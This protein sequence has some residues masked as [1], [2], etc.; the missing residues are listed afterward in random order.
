MY[1]PWPQRHPS[2]RSLGTDIA[3]HLKGTLAAAQAFD[4][5]DSFDPKAT[6]P[7][8]LFPAAPGVPAAT[9]A[10]RNLLEAT[11]TDS[12]KRAVVAA[13]VSTS[14]AFDALLRIVKARPFTR[15]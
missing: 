2:C 3:Q 8:P 6:A 11:S 12:G 7:I 1:C 9:T 13:L 14:G 5:L 4:E 15:G 10:V